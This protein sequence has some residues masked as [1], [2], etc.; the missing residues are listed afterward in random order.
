MTRCKP[1]Y[2]GYFSLYSINEIFST[3]S[4]RVL[5]MSES[6]ARGVLLQTAGILYIGWG[7]S[8][9][10]D[11]IWKTGLYMILF[12]VELYQMFNFQPYSIFL[13]GF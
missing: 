1:V 7:L 8:K 9:I 2:L 13:L 10:R 12:Y 11:N 5:T 4:L 3:C 6:F